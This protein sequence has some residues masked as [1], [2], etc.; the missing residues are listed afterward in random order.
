VSISSNVQGLI[1]RDD[2]LYLY[3]GP[4]DTPPGDRCSA[5][6]LG[7]LVDTGLRRLLDGRPSGW[8]QLDY[9]VEFV[10]RPIVVTARG[11]LVEGLRPAGGFAVEVAAGSVATGRAVPVDVVPA[12]AAGGSVA[13]SISALHQQL[14]VLAAEFARVAAADRASA[15]AAVERVAAHE[16]RY[17]AVDTAALLAG[18][19]PW[20]HHVHSVSAGQHEILSGVLRQVKEVSA[21]RRRD[22][23]LPRPVVAVDLDFCALLPRRRV[24]AALSRIGRAH[25]IGKLVAADRLAVLPGLYPAGWPLFLAHNRLREEQPDLDWDALHAEFRKALSWSHDA[26]LTDEPAP[27]LVR[28]VRAV[29]HAGGRVVWV[30]GRRPRMRPATCELLVRHG[31]GHLDLRTTPEHRDVGAHKVE[32]L[33]GRTDPQSKVVAVFDDLES[34]RAALHAAFPDA[35][36]VAVRP[37]GFSTEPRTGPG[38]ATFE[39]LPHPTPLGRGHATRQQRARPRL[40]HA[41]SI[42]EL[43]IG[44]LST[45]PTIWDRGVQLTAEQQGR[46]IEALCANAVQ[47]GRKLGRAVR[48]KLPDSADPAVLARAVRKVLMA[49]QFG[50]ARSAY[51]PEAAEADMAAAIAAGERITFVMLGP[52][53]KQD[54]SR[55][56]AVGGAPD[57]AE[58]AVLARIRQLAAAVEQVHPPGI[59]VLALADPSH[60]RTRDP[61]RC[62]DYHRSFGQLLEQT[63][64]HRVVTIVDID[65][66]AE[67]HPGCGDRARRPDL[68]AKHRD[69]YAAAFAGLDV[70]RD[71]LAVLAEAAERDPRKPGQP[72]FVEMFRSVLHA[73]D[74]PHRG[75]DPFAWSQQL[76]ADPY[77][78]DNPAVPRRIRS[79]RADL[80]AA[81]WRET[82]TYLAN[83]RV[84]D[85]L[86]YQALWQDGR[87]RMSL[88]IRPADGRFRFIPIGGSGVMPWHGTAALNDQH[89]VSVDYAI[90]LVH[91]GFLP[92]YPPGPGPSDGA[93]RQPWFMVPANGGELDPARFDRIRLRAK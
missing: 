91:Q 7:E 86:N 9:L 47:T 50:A 25:G 52:P 88:S 8:S 46:I 40:S 53:V 76:Y 90:S 36:V 29:E 51:P 28:F 58:V 61:R 1:A 93:V 59:R 41:T 2:L 87:V 79:A 11:L 85:E 12:D 38:I 34:N 42:A 3:C 19:H 69:R 21:S 77:E 60:F 22:R 33:R 89:E 45:H 5:V 35:A 13:E 84:D 68:L 78:L 27:G 71:P 72:R 32:A 75:G 80:L 39:F 10:V 92:V 4:P 63:G 26:L 73:I 65:D 37:T 43:P 82:I 56:K 15:L 17:L 14:S 81:A 18:D 31:L 64:A 57:L 6:P 20:R 16:L 44:E 70:R 48:E 30:T 54:G 62:T 83:K 24:R 66:A 49:K 55:L 74:V 67:A 23:S